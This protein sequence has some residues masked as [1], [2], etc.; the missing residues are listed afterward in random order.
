M[1]K[2][3]LLTTLLLVASFSYA[4]VLDFTSGVTI[5]TNY[6]TFGS[7]ATESGISFSGSDLGN[8]VS[9]YWDT[10]QDLSSWATAT[11]A[12]I[13]GSMTSAPTSVFDVILYDSNFNTVT[14]SGGSWVNISNV[15]SDALVIPANS[16]AWNDV[17]A[18][19]INT[20]G[21]GETVT[22]TITNISIVPE[23][24]TYALIAG[25]AAFLFVAIRRRK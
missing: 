11:E 22:G 4:E 10:A 6:D 7:T 15:G 3:L 12:I 8:V 17:T 24:S 9:A 23:P 13:S 18:F 19:D 21:A 2:S 20:G 16:F 25:F 1:K 14:L 5:D